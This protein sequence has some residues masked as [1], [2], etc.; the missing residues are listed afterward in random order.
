MKAYFRLTE[1]YKTN[2]PLEKLVDRYSMPIG[3]FSVP[4]AYELVAGFRIH[5]YKCC[6]KM[7][8]T[9]KQGSNRTRITKQ[10][11]N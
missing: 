9:S 3:L 1:T 11:A 8:P 10:K 5:V 2:L 6:K 4:A 7:S